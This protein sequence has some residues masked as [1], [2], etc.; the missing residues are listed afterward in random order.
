MTTVET[1]AVTAVPQAPNTQVVARSCSRRAN[2]SRSC[3]QRFL[4]LRCA[5]LRRLLHPG[6][7]F[8]RFGRQRG[9]GFDIA[10]RRRK[11]LLQ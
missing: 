3:L 8:D 1:A 10:S 11:I 9:L 6:S 7:L 2:R 4:Q 5:A